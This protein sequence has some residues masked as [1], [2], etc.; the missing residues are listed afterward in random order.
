MTQ[1]DDSTT[2]VLYNAD[3]PVCSYEIDHYATYSRNNALPIRFDDLNDTA[4]LSKWNLDGDAAA[5]RLHVLKDGELLSGIPAFVALWQE[6]PRYRWLA[7]TVRLPG[8]FHLA[9]GLYDHALAPAIYRWHLA[10]LR[11]KSA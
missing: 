7:R 2:S 6:M 5:R 10:R 3:C 4:S 1:P 9:C 11:R 8:V